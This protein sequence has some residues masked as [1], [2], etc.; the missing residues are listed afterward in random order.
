M[1]DNGSPSQGHVCPWWL[2]PSFDNPLRRLFQNPERILTGLVSPGQAAADLGCGMGYFSIPLAQLVGPAGRVFAVDLQAEMLAGV[3]RR[4]RR[5][6]LG[7]HLILHRAAPDRIGLEAPVDFVLAFW[8]LHEV[9]DQE[10]FLA[11]VRGFLK[12]GGL[13]LLVEPL[14]HVS[15]KDFENSL[16]RARRA[17]FDQVDPHPV[18]LSR[19][20]LMR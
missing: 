4:A 17:G 19:A 11:E 18:A 3:E 10:R 12:P 14:L 5:A 16:L 8:M 7:E 6:G 20:V 1:L 9:P 13:F 15:G 2:T